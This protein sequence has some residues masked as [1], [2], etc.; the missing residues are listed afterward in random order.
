MNEETANESAE[1]RRPPGRGRDA[2]FVIVGAGPA[3]LSAA[4]FLKK[5][6]YRNVT[7]IEKLGRVGGLCFTVTEDYTCFDLGANYVTPDYRE[8]LRL[9]DEFG[10]ERYAERN[11]V[12]AEIDAKKP[13]YQ[14]RSPWDAARGETSVFTFLRACARY[15][16]LRW[17]LRPVIDPPGHA[18]I[19][20]RTDLC[21]PF[22][23]WLK[24]NG[25]G[26]L[27]RLFEMPISIM[28]YGYLHEIPAP[29]A[30]KYLP[31]RT[32]I[33]MCIKAFP[34][35]SW[36]P[37]PKRFN[38]GFQWLWECVA[39]ELNVWTNIDIKKIER[40]RD[41]CGIWYEHR[42][43]NLNTVRFETDDFKFDYL[44]LTCPLS[45]DVMKAVDL[46]LSDEERELFG[47]I[48]TDPYC[49][50]SLKVTLPNLPTDYAMA[51][52]PLTPIRL[53]PGP[54]RS[55]LRTAGSSSSIRDSNPRIC[56]TR[57]RLGRR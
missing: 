7:V 40:S 16:W 25:L 1:T 23:D 57:R 8:T 11:V 37:W 43:Q 48:V 44:I 34:L 56:T 50:T 52:I 13:G 5:N 4:Y 38:L 17:K 12:V 28:G 31:T 54:S 32:F 36:L 20:S 27:E 46:E 45:L 26:C 22:L 33:A 29:Y 9:A 39:R 3:G 10:V 51:T 21:V 30:L 24:A 15:A 55:R 19:S 47:Q 35:T 6:G 2:E 14:A 42:E 41:G 18:G 53:H 49:M